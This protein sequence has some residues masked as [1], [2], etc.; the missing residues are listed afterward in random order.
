MMS[1]GEVKAVRVHSGWYRETW[2]LVP[3]H[4]AWYY[5]PQWWRTVIGHLSPQVEYFCNKGTTRI[6]LRDYS[7]PS[8]RQGT[9]DYLQETTY[10]PLRDITWI[11]FFFILLFSVLEVTLGHTGAVQHKPGHIVFDL[12]IWHSGIIWHWWIESI[13]WPNPLSP[14]KVS[15]GQWIKSFGRF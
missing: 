5:I 15:M 10:Y 4:E 7:D 6:N 11:D 13:A 12:Q 8:I 14:G 3:I 9:Q 1:R 2:H